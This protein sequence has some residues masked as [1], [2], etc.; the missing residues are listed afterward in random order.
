M[1]ERVATE[2]ALRHAKLAAESAVRAREIFLANM[3][4]EIRTPMNAILGMSQLLL[5]RRLHQFRPVISK[6][7]PPRPTTCWSSSMIFWTS[8][9]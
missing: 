5:K 1:T 9:S 6:P 3:S 2:R 4:H 7:L 8:P